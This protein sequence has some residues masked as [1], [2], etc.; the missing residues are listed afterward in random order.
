MDDEVLIIKE[1]PQAKIEKSLETHVEKEISN[2]DSYD[3][4]NEKSI[5]KEECNE[6]KEKE[7][8][9]EKESLSENPCYFYS[10]S[11]LSEKLEKDEYSKE[12]NFLTKNFENEESL[13]YKINKTISFF[14]P[15]SCLCFDHFHEGTELNSF[16][17]VSYRNSL[18]HPCT[19]TS[20]LGRNHTMKGEDQ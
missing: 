1:L 20:K 15:N 3:I 7:R 9:E 12:R 4:K 19:W 17:L 2:W 5:E 18:E 8:V 16:E 6:F 14:D 11:T 13:D 10:I